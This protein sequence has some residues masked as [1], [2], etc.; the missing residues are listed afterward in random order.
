[1]DLTFFVQNKHIIEGA[2]KQGLYCI[3]QKLPKES[4]AGLVLR[5]AGG[6]GGGER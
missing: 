6:L 5:D 3:E 1:M 4:R 2:E